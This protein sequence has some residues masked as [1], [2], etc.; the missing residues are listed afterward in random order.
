MNDQDTTIVI[1]LRETLSAFPELK[2]AILFG[3][4]AKG[5]E[6][7]HSDLDVAVAAERPLN[8]EQKI[9]MIEKLSQISGRSIDLIDLQTKRETIF[10]QAITKGQL[11]FCHD[12]KLYAEIIKTVMFNAADFL[13]LRSRIL[14]DRRHAWINN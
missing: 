7:K 12:T 9:Q 5:K 11:I 14:K 2:L 8:A 4:F 3:S 10:S 1:Q 6:T 13:P